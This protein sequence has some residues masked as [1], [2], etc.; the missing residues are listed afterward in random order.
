MKE[1]EELL[2]EE[3]SSIA[4]EVLLERNPL[5]LLKDEKIGMI[6]PEWF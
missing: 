4:A 6:E 1:V 3:F 5:R 2:R